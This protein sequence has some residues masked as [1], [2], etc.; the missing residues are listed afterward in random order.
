MMLHRYWDNLSPNAKRVAA[1]GGG[2]FVVSVLTAGSFLFAPAQTMGLQP[3]SPR[4]TLVRNILTDA[5]PRQL[6]IEALVNRLERMEKRMSEVQR[7][8]ERGATAAPSTPALGPV[9]REQDLGNARE[10]KA[11]RAEIDQL[12]EAL[13]AQARQAAN[14]MGLSK[15]E[16]IGD[17]DPAAPAATTAQPHRPAPMEALFGPP[18]TLPEVV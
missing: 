18:T 16:S 4:D 15:P 13:A 10:L 7:N 3:P 2:V 6:G 11:L 5:D 1:L 17:A 14:P 12:R 9:Q 8:L